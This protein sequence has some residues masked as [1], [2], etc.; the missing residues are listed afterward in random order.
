ME[1]CLLHGGG[2]SSLFLVSFVIILPR[3][4]SIFYFPLIGGF[5]TFHALLNSFIHFMMYIYYGVA[6]LGPQYQ[7]FLWWKK[8]MTS[9]QIVSTIRSSLCQFEVTV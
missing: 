4:V 7:K 1:S 3:F 8:Y 2:E 9:M 6:G 5:G